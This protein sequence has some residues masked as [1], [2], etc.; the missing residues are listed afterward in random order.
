M[1]SRALS[2]CSRIAMAFDN[3]STHSN[4]YPKLAP[5]DRSV[6]QLPGSM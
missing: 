5:P 2:V 3:T 1:P 4:R 6:T